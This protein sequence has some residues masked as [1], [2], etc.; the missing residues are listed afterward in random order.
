[1]VYPKHCGIQLYTIYVEG[2]GWQYAGGW[3]LTQDDVDAFLDEHLG[4]N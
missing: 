2:V 4:P 3:S 1:M